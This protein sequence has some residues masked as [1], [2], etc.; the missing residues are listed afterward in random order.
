MKLTRIVCLAVLAL[1]LAAPSVTGPARL[2]AQSSNQGGLCISVPE[3]LIPSKARRAALL[4]IVDTSGSMSGELPDAKRSL[5]GYVE[6]LSSSE[7]V[8]LRDFG[9]G[10]CGSVPSPRV[11]VQ[12]L[13]RERMIEQ[14]NAMRSDGG[15]PLTQALSQIPGDLAAYRGQPKEVIL[16]ADGDESCNQDPVAMVEQLVAS[17]SQLTIHVISYGFNSRTLQDIALISGGTYVNADDARDLT[18]VLGIEK[19]VAY[20]V[21]QNGQV[22]PNGVGIANNEPLYL[23]AG[24]YTVSVPALDVQNRTV[25]VRAGEGTTLFVTGRGSIEIDEDDARCYQGT[26]PTGRVDDDYL[27]GLSEDEVLRVAL[28]AGAAVTSM[29]AAAGGS[30]VLRRIR[31]GPRTNRKWE[32]EASREAPSGPCQGDRF[33]VHKMKLR[34]QLSRYKIKYLAMHA[35]D[36]YSGRQVSRRLK[37]ATVKQLNRALRAYGKGEDHRTLHHGVVGLSPALARQIARALRDDPAPYQVSLTAHIVGS[38][39]KFQF[40]LYRCVATTYK[41]EWQKVKDWETTIRDERDEP[42][43]MV[44]D[45]RQYEQVTWDLIRG[46]TDFVRRV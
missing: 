43:V 42:V 7:N 4:M 18:R 14:I 36:S 30:A 37:G 35:T 29:A 12:R 11:P 46:L 39:V 5:T 44:Q 17:D 32:R 22:L 24:T 31:R 23:S 40:T 16:V 19:R 25:R 21:A 1:L 34:P 28:V 6:S 33:R 13:D 26:V 41:S 38:G 45:T 8:G 27:F 10:S 20:E 3:S 2:G 15:T 9:S